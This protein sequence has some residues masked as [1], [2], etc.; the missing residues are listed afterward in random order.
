MADICHFD[1]DDTYLGTCECGDDL[2]EGVIHDCPEKEGF[3]EA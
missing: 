1:L 3:G 2:Y